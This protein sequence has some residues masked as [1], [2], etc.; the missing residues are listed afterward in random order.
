LELFPVRFKVSEKL[1][2][3]LLSK[4]YYDYIEYYDLKKN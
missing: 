4:E 3:K 2:N 1:K